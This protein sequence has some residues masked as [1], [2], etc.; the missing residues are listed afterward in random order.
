ME[1]KG[2][3]VKKMGILTFLKFRWPLLIFT[4]LFIIS[5]FGGWILIEHNY[6]GDLP[7][8]ISDEITLAKYKITV[9]G[10]CTSPKGSS[11]IT[12]AVFGQRLYCTAYLDSK[13]EIPQ[14]IYGVFITSSMLNRSYDTKEISIINNTMESSYDLLDHGLN[15]VT[16]VI[17]LM[18][19]KNGEPIITNA[20]GTKEYSFNVVSNTDYANI[21]NQ[22]ILLEWGVITFAIFSLSLAIKNLT[23]LWDRAESKRRRMRSIEI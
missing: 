19:P 11:E 1:M 5:M 3:K 21:Q 14:N 13:K 9:S 17:R 2:N 10:N 7:I 12:Y 22:K 16:F 6:R 23:D 4:V 18:E 20:A 8:I 15:T